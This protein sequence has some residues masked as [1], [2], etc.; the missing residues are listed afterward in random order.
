MTKM[1]A[2]KHLGQHF[3]KSE[4]ALTQIVDAGDIHSDDIVLEIGPGTGALTSKL[5]LL[6]DK[7][8]A[9]EK[10]RELISLL[11]EKF[12]D[13]IKKTRLDIVEKDILK[14]DP[15]VMHFYKK[16]YKLIA[17]IPYYITGAIIEKFLSAKN[18]PD[19]IVL[20]IQKEVAERIV[21]K[22]GKESVLSIAVK[23]Y[24]Q[25]KIIAKVP[26]GAFSPAP[27]VDSAVISIKNI[28]RDFFKDLPAQAGCDEE[29]FFKVLK[30]VF[31]KKRKQ[32]EG[33]L[34]DFIKNRDRA[35]EILSKTRLD[36]KSRPEN[37]NFSDWKKLVR[38]IA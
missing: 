22:D 10:D 6:A 4:K 2:K 27:K 18:Q 38:H 11:N 9:V 23:V 8:V 19:Q 29:V 15:E 13:A 30:F 14:F 20:L 37:L 16:P 31:G 17:N 36:P 35:K 25:P 34:A 21:A 24:G 26:A 1:K 12:S 5:I 32:I 33:S 3:L 28:S 7:V